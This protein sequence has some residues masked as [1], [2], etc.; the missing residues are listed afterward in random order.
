MIRRELRTCIECQKQQGRRLEDMLQASIPSVMWDR[1]T[2][3]VVYMPP[4]KGGYHFL[5]IAREY[6]SGWIEARALR[7]VSAAIV[8]DFIY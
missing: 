5:L 1:W 6:L 3:D 7:R 2:I 8:A 4:T